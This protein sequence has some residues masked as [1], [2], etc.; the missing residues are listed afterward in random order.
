MRLRGPGLVDSRDGGVGMGWDGMGWE[1]EREWERE[2]ERL[3]YKSNGR[4]RK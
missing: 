2:C 3:V 4:R 1:W